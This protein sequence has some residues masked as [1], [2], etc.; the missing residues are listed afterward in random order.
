MKK[1][2]H[3]TRKPRKA[4]A[5]VVR[6]ERA[7]RRAARKIQA[8]SRSHSLPLIA[9]KDGKLVHKSSSGAGGGRK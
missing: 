1:N 7:F 4:P 3:T 6:A 9:W 8:E 2:G 5:F